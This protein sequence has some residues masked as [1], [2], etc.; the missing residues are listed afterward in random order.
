MRRGRFHDTLPTVL[1]SGR[2]ATGYTCNALLRLRSPGIDG[3]RFHSELGLTGGE[4]TIFFSEAHAAGARL[5]HAPEAVLFE[6]IPPERACFRW[7]FRRRYRMGHTHAQVLTEVERQSTLLV[8]A[9]AFLKAAAC[10]ALALAQLP[11]AVKRNRAILRCAL[12]IGT[13]ASIAGAP[14][15]RI[16]DASPSASGRAGEGGVPRRTATQRR[17]Q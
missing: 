7:L 8:A 9:L 14:S 10:A 1:A 5:V 16:Y 2:I 11:F 12:H 3:R 4:D 13:L 6:D 15:I 17:L